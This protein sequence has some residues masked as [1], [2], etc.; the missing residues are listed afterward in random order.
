MTQGDLVSTAVSFLLTVLVLSYIWRDNPLFRLT[1]H[2]FIGVAAGYAG[3]VALNK[4]ILPQLI[5]PFLQVLDGG[6]FDILFLAIPPLILG[7]LLFTKLS[8]RWAWLGNPSM[9]FLVG[10]GTAAAIG[11]AVLGTLFP[12]I[13][14][15]TEL[16]NFQ[17]GIVLIGTV[18]TL[19]YF[20][21]SA[22]GEPDKKPARNRLLEIIGWGGQ[23][24]IAVTFG[25]IFAGVY[26]AALT[27]M[28]E[29]LQFLLDFLLS[30]S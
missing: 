11:G 6:S 28:I 26:A 9:A 2:I 7:F 15:S 3:A 30:F 17:S 16:I 13:A 29:R 23:A 14:A 1:I 8:S 24:F 18:A 4:V 21:F 12:Q 10:I 27:A 5:Q 22:R 20:Q 25:V 19:I